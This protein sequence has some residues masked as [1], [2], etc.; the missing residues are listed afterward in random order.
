MHR[1]TGL[2]YYDGPCFHV[3]LKNQSGERYTLADGGFV[4][5]TRRM[6]LD[7]KERPLTSAIGIELLCRMSRPSQP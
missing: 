6:L 5:W 7:D 1:L 2:G 4:D 3:V